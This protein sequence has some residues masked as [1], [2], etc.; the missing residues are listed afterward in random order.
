MFTIAFFGEFQ[1][2]LSAQTLRKLVGA[3]RKG[4]GGNL[5]VVCSAD[6][7]FKR[8]SNISTQVGMLFDSGIDYVFSGESAISRHAGRNEL[9][10]RNW[11]IVSPMNLADSSLNAEVMEITIENKK[12]QFISCIQSTGRIPADDEI[13]LLNSLLLTDNDADIIIVNLNGTDIALK[14]AIA[15]KYALHGKK[16]CFVGNGIGKLTF[17]E[18]IKGNIYIADCGCVK[19]KDS[20]EGVSVSDWWNKKIH[21][22]YTSYSPP[23]SDLVAD[24][25]IINYNSLCELNLVEQKQLVV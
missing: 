18:M 5:I 11:P 23:Q 16:I 8:A 14:E 19:A 20:L 24:L 25:T 7:I 2:E 12:L 17:G 3:V 10:N 15:Y 1:H 6:G 13:E 21:K 22:E 4:I 9:L